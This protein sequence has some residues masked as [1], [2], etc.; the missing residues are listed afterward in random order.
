MKGIKS[1]FGK[2][3]KYYRKKQLFSQ[4]QLAEKLGI[5]PKH[6]S[7]IETGATFVSA[8]LL[9]KFT[10]QLNVSA[11][12]L[13][14]SNDEISTDDSLLGQID[15]IIDKECEKT[16]STIKMQIRYLSSQ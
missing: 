1:I 6:L 5:T 2:N 8:D 14:Y 13:F 16:S 3:I 15:H 4:E 10:Q 12:A 7:T 11:S 9:E